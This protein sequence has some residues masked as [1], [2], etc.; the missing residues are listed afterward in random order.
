MRY[1]TYDGY[2]EVVE[3]FRNGFEPLPPLPAWHRCRQCAF[4]VPR[5]ESPPCEYHIVDIPGLH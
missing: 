1:N 2:Q 4:G 3:N 5:W